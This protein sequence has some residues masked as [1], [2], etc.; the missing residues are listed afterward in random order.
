MTS[1]V[2]IAEIYSLVRVLGISCL[3]AIKAVIKPSFT[4]STILTAFLTGEISEALR[5]SPSGITSYLALALLKVFL[6]I[7]ILEIASVTIM[8]PSPATL[9]RWLTGQAL[10]LY[11]V[12][13]CSKWTFC[14][15]SCSIKEWILTSSIARNAFFSIAHFAFSADWITILASVARGVVK[16][17]CWAVRYALV[18]E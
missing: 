17:V 11:L 4:S 16:C 10:S 3:L 9:A 12:T 13:I 8:W 1:V 7:W 18:F 2:F 15:A 6:T 5:H 14:S